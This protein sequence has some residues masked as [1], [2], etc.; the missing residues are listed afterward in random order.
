MVLHA[1][2][3]GERILNFS[4]P[5]KYSCLRI[6]VVPEK[7]T[8]IPPFSG[9]LV[10]TLLIRANPS[11]DQVFS[12]RTLNPKPIHVSPLGYI[13]NRGRMRFLWK[14]LKKSSEVM[15]VVGGMKY[16]F[17]VGFE[18]SIEHQVLE[19]M[20]RLDGVEAYGTRWFVEEIDYR[21]IELPT[22]NPHIRI[23]GGDSVV[24]E[25]RSPVNIIDPYKKTRYRRFLPVAGFLF[26]YNIGDLARVMQR[27]ELYWKL[28]NLVNA[29]LQETHTVWETVNKTYYIYDGKPLPGLTGY[30][31][32]YVDEELVKDDE[33]LKLLIENMLVHASIMGVGSGRASGFGYVTIK[34]SS[35]QT[36]APV[37]TADSGG[38]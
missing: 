8:I 32:Y 27:D 3:N 37:D 4:S 35:Q 24:V 20:Y 17:H 33:Y 31:K 2:I 21:T 22:Q 19:V 29:V 5:R 11:L 13:D 34:T 6:V 9:K 25:F 26:S 12:S 14:S 1:S 28:V 15:R 30:I 36:G 7:N 23:S 16:F 10:K 38:E 18:E